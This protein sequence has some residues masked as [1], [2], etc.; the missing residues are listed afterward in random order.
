MDQSGRNSSEDDLANIL[1]GILQPLQDPTQDLPA[2]V[3]VIS[4]LLSLV[5]LAFSLIFNFSLLVVICCKARTSVGY[6]RLLM[7]YCIFHLLYQATVAWIEGR[8][9]LGTWLPADDPLVG[10]TD[11]N[12]PILS[13]GLLGTLFLLVSTLTIERFLASTVGG[14]VSICLQ[15]LACLLALACPALLSAFHILRRDGPPAAARHAYSE[16]W[17]G[18][19]VGLYILLPLLIITVF[20]T[21]NYCKV[22]I[23][24]RL[25][26]SQE[27]QAV[28]T[29]I[30]L[31]VLTNMSIFLF[32]IQECL[33]LWQE[34]LS[35]RELEDPAVQE[36][37]SLVGM[38]RVSVGAGLGLI[39]ALA[40]P[41]ALCC[42]A[43]C[44][45]ACCC[46]SINQL[47]ETRY[48]AI[49]LLPENVSL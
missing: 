25:M 6:Y 38:C 34:Q 8:G 41:I 31:V 13:R 22:S 46:P 7:L 11:R 23:S 33:L 5:L 27:V 19:E 17:F 2:S 15:L 39:Q 47:E 24:S 35:G 1:L 28:K 26:R 32:L 20:G 18:L 48:K 36:L 44:C 42:T 49:S 30:G 3:G 10:W 16:L 45:A 14:V 29:N 37:V 12:L 40:P 43:Q 4:F 9:I 21:V